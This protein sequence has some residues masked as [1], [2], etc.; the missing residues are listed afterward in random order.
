[1]NKGCEEDEVK[2]T[3]SDIESGMKTIYLFSDT[4]VR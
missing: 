3:I 2:E 1:M 4:K